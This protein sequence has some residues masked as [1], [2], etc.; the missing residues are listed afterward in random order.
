MR[1]ELYNLDIA[2]YWQLFFAY[3]LLIENKMKGAGSAIKNIP[4]FEY[5]KAILVPIP[6]LQ[7]QKRIIDVAVL[8]DR[9]HQVIRRKVLV[10]QY[11]RITF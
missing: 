6:P 1:V 4:P 10:T 7:E 2:D 9:Y 8:F 5:L 11:L 3:I